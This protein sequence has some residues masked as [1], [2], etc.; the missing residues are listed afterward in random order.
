MERPILLG[1]EGDAR[2]MLDEADCG[3]AFEPSNDEE[4]A[5]AAE[6][7]AAAPAEERRRL[8]EN[9]RRYVLEHFDRR[10]LAHDYLEILERV[11]A[12]QRRRPPVNARSGCAAGRAAS[13]AP[14]G[15]PAR[16]PAVGCPRAPTAPGGPHDR[17]E[18]DHRRR[19]PGSPPSPATG[20]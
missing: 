12:D 5:A 4:L 16:P 1:F 7:L 2:A 8:G 13:R 9:G 17:R 18:H 10:M 20:G 14:S 6:R 15:G 11:R 19:R 3:I